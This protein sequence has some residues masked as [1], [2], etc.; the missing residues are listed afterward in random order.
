MSVK[1]RRRKLKSGK[2]SLYLDL[3]REGERQYEFLKLYLGKDRQANKETLRLAESIRA[4]RQLELQNQQ[5]GFVPSFKQK[6]DF[7]AY[8]RKLAAGK[9]THDSAWRNTLAKLEAFTGGSIPTRS[10]TESWLED[11]KDFLLIEVAQL[12]ARTY[13]SKVR[14]ALRQAQKDKIIAFNPVDRVSHIPRVETERTFLTIEDLQKLAATTDQNTRTEYDTRRAF[15]F[16]CYTGLRISDVRA[17]R[18][19]H[20]KDGRL[21]FKQKKTNGQEY[22]PLSNQAR[23]LLGA[24]GDPGQPVFD[25]PR[26]HSS[27]N[28]NL[29]AW[30]K[31]A[32]LNKHLSFHVSRHTFA[33]LAL[34]HDVDLYTVSKLLGHKSLQTT[35]VY[36]RIIDKKK[37]EAV[38]RLPEIKL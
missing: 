33:T 29:R 1:L 34:T 5:Y 14:A 36:A 7:V 19:K 24:P 28:T 18:W 32:G 35:Q 26:N 20:V 25:L 3:Y 8:F 2:T 17:L 4:K 11:F 9:G 6:T 22:L 16:A 30:A 13:F 15:L 27:L 23:T 12:T 10:I 31:A 21:H 37:Q 38:D